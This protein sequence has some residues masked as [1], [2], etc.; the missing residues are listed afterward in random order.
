MKKDIIINISSSGELLK[1]LY[2]ELKKLPRGKVKSYLEHRQV[3]VNGVVT[4]K[5]N[6]PLKPGDTVKI[7]LGEGTQ[8]PHR[9]E[10]LYEDEQLIAVNKPAGLLSVA[11]DGEKQRTAYSRLSE[12][13]RGDVFVVHRLDRDTS[14]VLLFAKSRQIRDALQ[15][16][17]NERITLREYFAI[18]EGDFEQ[19]KGR[20]DSLIAENRVHVMYSAREGKRAITD[21]EVVKARGGFSLV[22]VKL[23][24][25][26]KNQIRVHMKELGH[27]VVG[28]KKYGSSSNPIGRLGLHAAALGFIHPVTGKEIIIKAGTERKFTLPKK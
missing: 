1:L 7:A 18:C 3:L 23:L 12:A 2:E 5:F 13:R 10:I 11:S 25:G 16:D 17:W 15:E 6:H 8:M 19:K 26:R 20:C 14:G 28:D 4:T 9:L 22:R 24:T 27:L 21:Y